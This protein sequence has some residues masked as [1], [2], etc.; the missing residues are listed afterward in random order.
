MA[1]KPLTTDTTPEEII[2]PDLKPCPFCGTV[3]VVRHGIDE[4]ISKPGHFDIWSVTCGYMA[5]DVVTEVKSFTTLENAA[6]IWNR[7]VVPQVSAVDAIRYVMTELDAIGGDTLEVFLDG[8]DGSPVGAMVPT[9][10]THLIPALKRLVSHSDEE[11]ALPWP[12]RLDADLTERYGDLGFVT[13]TDSANMEI[14][15]YVTR[16]NHGIPNSEQEVRRTEEIR[17]WA[18]QRKLELLADDL[19][20]EVIV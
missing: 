4:H 3:P 18:E 6:E 12:V 10:R 17:E 19:R 9:S 14:E 11:K 13:S 7:R 15:S 16:W 2:L 5:C 20:G 1:K 8:K